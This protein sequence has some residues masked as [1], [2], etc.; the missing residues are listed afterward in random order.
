MSRK[1]QNCNKCGIVC[2]YVTFRL[3]FSQ[4]TVM[5]G[6]GRIP[7]CNTIPEQDING[8]TVGPR[9]EHA[10]DEADSREEALDEVHERRVVQRR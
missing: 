8:S 5:P 1:Q 6:H 9:S 2:H 7:I 4:L 10:R 3:L